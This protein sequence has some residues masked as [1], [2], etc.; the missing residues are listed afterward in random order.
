MPLPEDYKKLIPNLIGRTRTRELQWSVVPE[1]EGY[2]FVASFE[3]YGLTVSDT[4]VP[5]GTVYQ[6]ALVD[7][8]GREIDSY[9]LS[10][11]DR[12]FDLLAAL[13]GAARRRAFSVDE[14]LKQIA[15]K[16]GNPEDEIHF[17]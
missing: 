3:K 8:N 7:Q 16:L 1:S 13:W 4:G 2:G 6:L 5:D 12:D 9:N 15:D 10:T 14:A 17:E 11:G